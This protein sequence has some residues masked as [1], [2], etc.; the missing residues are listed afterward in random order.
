[1]TTETADVSID[2]LMNLPMALP[3][4]GLRSVLLYSVIG[5]PK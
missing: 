2:V 1:M 4:I 3:L 5:R